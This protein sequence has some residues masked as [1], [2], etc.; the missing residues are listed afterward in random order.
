MLYIFFADHRLENY[1]FLVTTTINEKKG[2]KNTVIIETKRKMLTYVFERRYKNWGQISDGVLER[3]HFSAFRKH[4]IGE[5][6]LTS[7]YVLVC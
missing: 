6:N 4:L 1:T 3:L 2:Y 7:P 5:P